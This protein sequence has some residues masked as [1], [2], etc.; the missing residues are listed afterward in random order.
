M[1]G[2]SPSDSN[3]DRNI[4]SAKHN[5]IPLQLNEC[6]HFVALFLLHRS[7]PFVQSIRH[8]HGLRR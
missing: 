3:F 7:L 5:N 4:D 8:F 1:S 6:A 2:R